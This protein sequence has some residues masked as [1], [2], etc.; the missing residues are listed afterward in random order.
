MNSDCQF[1]VIK[2]KNNPVWCDNLIL[3]VKFLWAARDKSP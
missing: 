2:K 3:N 1:K